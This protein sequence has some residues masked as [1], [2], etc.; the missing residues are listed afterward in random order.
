L[1]AEEFK[2]DV[3]IKLD[4]SDDNVLFCV[5]LKN[6]FEELFDFDSMLEYYA[7]LIFAVNLTKSRKKA[8]KILEE[9]FLELENVKID[10]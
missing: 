9:K 5:S 10:G 4:W 7:D 6:T 3:T 8:L 1:A 2:L